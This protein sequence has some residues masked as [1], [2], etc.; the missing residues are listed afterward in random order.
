MKLALFF[1]H[2]FNRTDEGLIFSPRLYN[3]HFLRQRYLSDFTEVSIVARVESIAGVQSTDRF[4]EG[5][6]VKVV[7]VGNWHGPKDFLLKRHGVD[8]IVKE[9]ITSSEAVLLVSPGQLGQLAS[10]H[11]IR[12]QKPYGVEVVGDPHGVFAPGVVKHPLRA[13]LRAHITRQQ[14]QVVGSAAAVSYVTASSLQKRYPASRKAFAT[15]FSDIEMARDDYVAAARLATPLGRPVRCV[16]VGSL[17]QLY[18]GV[19]VLLRAARIC[20]DSGLALELAIIGD[21]KYRP[22]LERLTD[23]L[24][25]TGSVQFVGQL[26]AGP[27]VK[28]WLDNTDVFVLAS[29]T[30]GLPRALIEAMGRAMPCIA[31]RVGGIPE[32]LDEEDLVEPN[33]PGS[34][35]GKILEVATSSVRMRRMSERN[36][37]TAR[38]Y[39]PEQLHQRRAAFYAH[40]REVTLQWQE[41]L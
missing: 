14:Q 2:R 19:D 3:Y 37:E 7:S 39:R 20:R 34:L 6:G 5:P 8:R 9:Q 23:Q 28:S 36:L 33:E 13:L 38:D 16:T 12:M 22:D 40:I 29:R 41:R 17:D 35:A 24:G 10:R 1:D 26:P 30:E 31:T 21:G 18:K 25:L 27:A 15:H 4:A 11:L 32:L